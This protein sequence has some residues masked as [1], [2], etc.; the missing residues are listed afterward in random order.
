M[1]ALYCGLLSAGR[2]N[3]M[4]ARLNSSSLKLN[5]SYLVLSDVCLLL[6]CHFCCVEFSLEVTMKYEVDIDVLND[7]ITY[8]ILV[9][10]LGCPNVIRVI[11]VLTVSFVSFNM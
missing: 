8:A 7:Y 5:S 10:V 3:H 1:S 9:E 2:C 11:L 6:A 4:L